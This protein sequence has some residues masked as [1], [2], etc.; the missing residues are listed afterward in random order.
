MDLDWKWQTLQPP[1]AVQTLVSDT[2]CALK[3]NQPGYHSLILPLIV[4]INENA[5]TRFDDR[6]LPV[7]NRLK[8]RPPIFVQ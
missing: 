2:R 7:S 1:G 8:T 6:F 4:L 3:S 5:S